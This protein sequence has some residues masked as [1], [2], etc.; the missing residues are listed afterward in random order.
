MKDDKALKNKLQEI[1]REISNV[2]YFVNNISVNPKDKASSK[3]LNYARRSLENLDRI[4]R[5]DLRTLE[6][7]AEVRIEED[8]QRRF[9]KA[10]GT[11]NSPSADM[12]KTAN[13]VVDSGKDSGSL[14]KKA[15]A[16]QIRKAGISNETRST[17]GNRQ[18]RGSNG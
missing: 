15:I 14:I 4:A 12:V 16:E 11:I 3:N 1:Q 2:N 6:K 8:S 9:K 17:V 13:D 10:L 5:Q 7:N 18:H